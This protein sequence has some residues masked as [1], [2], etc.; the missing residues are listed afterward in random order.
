ME[1]GKNLQECIN[2]FIVSIQNLVVWVFTD[3]CFW[4]YSKQY[5]RL[6]IALH[7]SNNWK[8]NTNF[9]EF[10]CILFLSLCQRQ[11]TLKTHK[12]K[13]DIVTINNHKP[14]WKIFLL[15]QNKELEFY[16]LGVTL[17]FFVADAIIFFFENI[18]THFLSSAFYITIKFWTIGLLRWANFF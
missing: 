16:K 1:Q 12:R 11:S 15:L 14:S 8:K 9:I 17:T 4:S 13:T 5:P 6:L 10:V 2:I 3:S 7:I 18:F